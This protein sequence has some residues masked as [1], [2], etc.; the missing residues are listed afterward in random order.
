VKRKYRT[1]LL[2]L[3]LLLFIFL[4]YFENRLFFNSVQRVFL[5]PLLAVAM[6]FIHN[7]LAISLIL[8][9]MTF[10]VDFVL[11]FMSRRQR[12]EYVVLEHPTVFALVFTAVILLV[13]ILRTCML[14]YG[15]VL[16]ETLGFV[17]LVSIPNGLIEAYGIY[18]TIQKTLKQTISMKDLAVI[19]GLFFIAAVLEVGVAQVLLQT[20]SIT[21]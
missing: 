7:V 15:E 2:G 4:A 14:V 5:S 12:Y 17:L 1:V 3:I 13:S 16:L 10:Y 18:L 21:P 11:T 9:S 8:L 6:V 19:Y 20:I